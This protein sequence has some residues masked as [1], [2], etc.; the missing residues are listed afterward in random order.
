[1]E[2]LSMPP[3]AIGVGDSFLRDTRT[4][5]D[6]YKG[7]PIHATQGLHDAIDQ[8]LKASG[9]NMRGGRA[10]DLAAGSGAMSLRLK[11]R[12]Y[13]VIAADLLEDKFKLDRA[14]ADFV[15][16]DFNQPFAHLLP[17]D[18]RVVT[19]IE[20]IEHIEN[21]RHFLRE[22]RTLLACDGTL[23]VTTPNINSSFSKSLFIRQ[24]IFHWFNDHDYR[25]HGHITPIGVWQFYKM[26]QECG[27]RVRAH[28]THGTQAFR[29]RE[30]RSMWLLQQIVLRARGT[31]PWGD[32]SNHI[33]LLSLAS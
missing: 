11:D 4:D 15:R 18:S 9:T 22:C 17:H 28:T 7:L 24:D 3:R 13:D 26:F 31:T 23:V 10:I 5:V 32:G 12:G 8:T 20:I 27:L 6:Q 21:P 25:E 14:D 33:F 30:W 19:A 29:F 1:M 2:R 16:V